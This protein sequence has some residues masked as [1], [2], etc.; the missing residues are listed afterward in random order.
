[1]EVHVLQTSIHVNSP[2]SRWVKPK[3]GTRG[4]GTIET[5]I[6]INSLTRGQYVALLSATRT[7]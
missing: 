6:T 1:M 4:I 2:G 5:L 3:S 7:N